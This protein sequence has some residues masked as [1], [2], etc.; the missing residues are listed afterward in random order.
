MS[1]FTAWLARFV[2]LGLDLAAALIRGLL[3]APATAAVRATSPIVARPG[4]ASEV[5]DVRHEVLRAGR[6]RD[7]AVFTG[8]DDPATRHWVAMQG[9]RVVGVVSVMAAPFPDPWHDGPAPQWQLRGM[10]VLPGLRGEGVGKKLLDAV[11]TDVA[12]PMWCNARQ[13]A[14]GFYA[15]HGW[16]P[17]GDHFDVP[18]IGP[19]RRMSWG[20]A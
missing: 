19:H 16:T 2:Q 10:A 17:H 12:E 7:T 8:D 15:H 14:E 18:P 20:P 11:H 6:P 13:A 3:G 9:D 5:L 1:W 4:T